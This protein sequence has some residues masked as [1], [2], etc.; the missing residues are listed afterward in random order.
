MQL[1]LDCFG[2]SL[3]VGKLKKEPSKTYFMVRR[4]TGVIAMV[5]SAIMFFFPHFLSR[6]F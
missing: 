2:R 5:V 3:K 1:I 4:I 6:G